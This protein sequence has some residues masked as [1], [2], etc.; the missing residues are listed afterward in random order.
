MFSKEGLKA[1]HRRMDD[2]IEWYARFPVESL[3]MCISTGNRKIGRVWN[4]SLPPI[5]SCGGN[6]KE[7]KN[8][9]YDVKAC[10]QYTNVC[11]AR[12]RNYSILKRNF[13]L[14]WEQL[15]AKLA[16][17]RTF[18]YFRFH[19]GG[20]FTT[21]E[22]FAEMVKT[23]RMFPDFRFWTYTK[24]YNIVNEYVRK[25][26]GKR[27]KAVPENL[28]IM[29]SEWKGLPMDNPFGFP[30]F[31][32]VFRSLESAPVG[33]WKCPGNCETCIKA[34]RGCPFGESAWTW[35]H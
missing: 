22:Y 17:K 28:S 7:C 18:K 1:Y 14:Y 29:F 16:K 15:R 10:N 26:G 4:V 27:R 20:D 34:G 31:R 12:A 19:V 2:A 3:T 30:V 13:D 9:C 6:C 33:A 8:Y 21:A 35:D 25:H 23:A 11:K 24:S 5:L 32:C